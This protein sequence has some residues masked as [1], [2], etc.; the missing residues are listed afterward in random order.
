M[1]PPVLGTSWKLGSRC[2]VRFSTD[3]N[4]FEARQQMGVM[5]RLTTVQGIAT[6]DPN[7]FFEAALAAPWGANV[8]LSPH[9]YP[10]CA[11][12]PT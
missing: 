3:G 8:A 12:P 9:I 5:H 6:E 1:R 10:P 7:P 4:C 11:R 2:R